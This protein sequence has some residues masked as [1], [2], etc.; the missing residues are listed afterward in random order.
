MD[1]F[2]LMNIF[3]AP[4]INQSHTTVSQETPGTLYTF[5]NIN[6]TAGCMAHCKGFSVLVCFA[7]RAGCTT[8]EH[9]TLYSTG[10]GLSIFKS[11]LM[12]FYPWPVSTSAKL[13]T[14]SGP[15]QMAGISHSQASS[16]HSYTLS[17]PNHLLV[18]PS[19]ARNLML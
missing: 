13:Y 9:Y 18:P 7:D 3:Y 1:D 12:W 4:C 15:L 2:Q 17:I 19:P 8:S 14:Q 5:A 10:L 6:K 16:F 11:G